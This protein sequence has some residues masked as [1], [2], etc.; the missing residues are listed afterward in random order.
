MYQVNYFFDKDVKNTQ[1]KKD[2]L[3]NK[4]TKLYFQMEENDTVLLSPTI[5]KN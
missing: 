1:G 3:F 5:H 4:M 2:S